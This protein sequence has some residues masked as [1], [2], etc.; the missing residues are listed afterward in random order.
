MAHENPHNSIA[1]PSAEPSKATEFAGFAAP[2]SNTT[3]TPNQFFDVCLPN[4]SRGCIRITGHLIR[5]TL[6]WCDAA[7]RPQREQI[8]VSYGELEQ[9]AGISH[10]MI[11]SSLDEAVAK[12]FITC[13]EEGRPGSKGDAGASARYALKWD[14]TPRYARTLDE[15]RGFYGA[16]GNRTDIPNQYFDV[17]IPRETLAVTHVVG[18]VIRHSIGFQT[19]SGSRRQHA[20]LAYSQILRVSGL[21]SRR[22][23]AG[24]I[25]EAIAKG[26]VVRL[27]PGRF[28]AEVSERRSATYALRWNDGFHGGSTPKRIPAARTKYRSEKDTSG[29][30]EHSGKDTNNTPKRIPAGHSEKETIE[31]KQ[32]NETQKQHAVIA[33]LLKKAG[34]DEA[35]A[36]ALLSRHPL[37]NIRQQLE[38]LSVRH[39]T[40]N[41][42]GLLRRAIE[43]N[44]PA[45]AIRRTSFSGPAARPLAELESTEVSPPDDAY[46]AWLKQQETV[47]RKDFPYEYARFLAKRSRLRRDIEQEKGWMT[48]DFRLTR[49]DS[50]AGRLHAFRE[51]EGLPDREHWAATI[52]QPTKT[53]HQQT[54]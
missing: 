24:A 18:A 16:E 42:A 31:I 20:T 51:F 37:E 41:P 33:G 32:L 4:A 47:Y 35:G 2:V 50:E 46:L 28:S 48:R 52:H 53:K 5:K 23:L 43:G 17:V 36:A 38:W 30:S 1:L 54:S 49:H 19:P 39:A 11:R 10:G 6:G 22:T 15:F 12:H 29:T 13:V 8:E 26:Y 9:L 45:P 7:G 44:W 34:M 21:S 3:Y 14:T 25:R 40:Q 27:D